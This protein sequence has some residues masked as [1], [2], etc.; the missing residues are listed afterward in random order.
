MPFY[1][2]MFCSVANI[3]VSFFFITIKDSGLKENLEVIRFN[4][5]P[6]EKVFSVFSLT[7]GLLIAV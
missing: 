6:K 5:S 7:S 1:E 4:Q 3:N 2:A